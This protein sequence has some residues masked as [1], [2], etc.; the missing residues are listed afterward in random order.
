MNNRAHTLSFCSQCT[1]RK[2]DFKKG[3]ICGLINDIP[4]FQNTY[5]SYN[6][7]QTVLQNKKE[8]EYK[9]VQSQQELNSIEKSF[10]LHEYGISNGILGG[11]IMIMIALIWFFGGQYFGVVYFYPPILF[12]SGAYILFKGIQRR[13]LRKQK[14]IL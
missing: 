6:E 7:D 12:I 9:A 3:I 8:I 13:N 11:V 5:P 10:G 4:N 1:N 14:N 2:F